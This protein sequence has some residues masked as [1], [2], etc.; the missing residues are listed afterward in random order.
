MSIGAKRVENVQLSQIRAVMDK[1]RSLMAQ[2]KSVINLGIGEPDFPSPLHVNEAAKKALDDQET[3]Y[4]PNRGLLS[5]REALAKKLAVDNGITVDPEKEII[6]TVGAAE[7]LF[8][9]MV[10]LLNPGDEV[11][12]IEP[13]FP[14]YVNICRLVGAVPVPV[15]AREENGWVPDPE[16]IEKAITPRSKMIIINSPNNP[17][18]SVYPKEVLMSVAKICEKHN[19]FVVCDEIYEKIIYPGNTHFSIASMPGM[20]ELTITINGYS[21]AYAM[22]G[23]RLAY[24]V[25]K[26]ELILPMLKVHQYA[27]TCVATFA[28]IGAIAA[29]TGPQDCVVEMRNEFQRR[30]DLVAKGLNDIEGISCFTPQGAFYAFPNIKAFG[31]SSAEFCDFLLEKAGVAVVPGTT[32]MSEDGYIRLSYATSYE[33]LADALQRMKDALRGKYCS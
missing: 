1:A 4:A 7:A 17:S 16:D 30:R 15:A 6:I 3:H 25:A 20:D 19:I 28:Q 9:A 8:I 13:A 23:W 22:T 33:V 2:G 32:F 31:L 24:V 11:I 14:S 12:I 21:K 29:T 26:P 27:T 10:G 18:G 5:L